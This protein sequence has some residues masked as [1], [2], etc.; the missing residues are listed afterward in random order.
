MGKINT[1]GTVTWIQPQNHIK[2][3][4]RLHQTPVCT[5]AAVNDRAIDWIG[6][7]YILKN[8]LKIQQIF[9]TYY[10]PY[11]I[12]SEDYNLDFIVFLKE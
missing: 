7:N 2:G 6:T 1:R 5:C 12:N 3:R 11:W 8:C 9:L 10:K 4:P